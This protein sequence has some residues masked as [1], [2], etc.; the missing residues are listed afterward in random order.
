MPTTPVYSLPYPAATDPADVPIDLGELATAAEA[1]LQGGLFAEAP[2]QVAVATTTYIDVGPSVT[3][4]EAGDYL[5]SFGGHGHIST[6][7]DIVY[8]APKLGAAATADTDAASL[9]GTGA[10]WGFIAPM[11]RTIKRTL[12]AGAVVKIQGKSYTGS[13]Q[14]S[15]SARWLSVR[16]VA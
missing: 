15:V 14:G 8:L 3:V 1:A 5:I 16:R 11:S 12:A 9:S 2:T 4:P 7:G 10:T 6:G 13:S